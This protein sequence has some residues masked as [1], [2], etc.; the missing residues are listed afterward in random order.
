MEGVTREGVSQVLHCFLLAG[1][2][3][4]ESDN[5]DSDNDDSDSDD[6]EFDDTYRHEENTTDYVA[7]S[8]QPLTH[9]DQTRVEEETGVFASDSMFGSMA[10]DA[11]HGLNATCRQT[12]ALQLRVPSLD[13]ICP[14][15]LDN[16]S[17]SEVVGFE[18]FKLSTENPTLTEAVLPCGHSFSACYL[19]ISW[20][21]S[22][23]RCPLCRAGLDVTLD[24]DSIPIPWRGAAK[25]YVERLRA[26]EVQQQVT[27]TNHVDVGMH[28]IYALQI[29]M[30][31]YLTL[32]D[33]TV[34][35]MLV[36]FANNTSTRQLD[37]DGQLSLRV[38][39]AQV[40]AMSRSV[41]RLHATTIN[42]VVFA[43]RMG[44]DANDRLIEIA[45]SGPIE[46]PVHEPVGS[47]PCPGNG[48]PVTNVVIVQQTHMAG[49]D[50]SGVD[51]TDT[52]SLATF[53]IYWQVFANRVFDTLVDATFCVNFSALAMFI[54]GVIDEV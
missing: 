17:T 49:S 18:G 25:E 16:I 5:D 50:S 51:I 7:G 40:R 10:N 29:H 33:G 54:G 35:A 43:R 2:E 37:P 14:I 44:S 12:V 26:T 42:L 41:I 31:F 48:V 23:M 34:T 39:R 53:C 19:A 28:M 3:V 36:D 6:T 46:V 52:N 21:T 4:D 9:H 20:L 45:Q 1:N 15:S 30:C 32:A 27:D 38:T 24:I 47:S 13:A 11:D 8:D 22:A